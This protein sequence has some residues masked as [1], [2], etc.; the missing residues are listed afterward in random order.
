VSS[1]ISAIIALG[2]PGKQYAETRHNA[3]HWFIDRVH[4]TTWSKHSK[5]QAEF[6]QTT[7]DNQPV[8][9]FKSLVFVNNSGQLVQSL[10]QYYRIELNKVLI[11]HDELDLEVGEIKYKQ[12]GGH[13]GH[14][15]L[16]S[17]VQH[18]GNSAFL[19]LRIGIGHPGDKKLVTNYVLS[20]PKPQQRIAIEQSIDNAVA[21]LNPL[22][23]GDIEAAMRNLS[24]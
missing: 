19:R 7:I 16:R 1:Q 5:L 9:L 22:C 11:A 8:K 13:A 14:N 23:A 21:S 3:G 17:I 4:T 18:I 2:N 10:M 12:G 15:G 24:S 20:P 6:A